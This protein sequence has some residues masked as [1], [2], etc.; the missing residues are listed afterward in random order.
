[1]LLRICFGSKDIVGIFRVIL[2]MFLS[3]LNGA[4]ACLASWIKLCTVFRLHSDDSIFIDVPKFSS[5]SKICLVIGSYSC[6]SNEILL[7]PKLKKNVKI[8]FV[9][10]RIIDYIL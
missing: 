6:F 9:Q 2:K 8:S 5:L 1:M 3:P 4:L 10:I 7:S